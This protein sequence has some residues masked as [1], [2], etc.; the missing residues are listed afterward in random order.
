MSESLVVHVPCGDAQLQTIQGLFIT[1][2]IGE[3][4]AVA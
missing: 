3:A 4:A 2:S 1:Y